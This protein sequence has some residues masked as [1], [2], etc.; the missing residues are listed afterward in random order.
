MSA[1][2]LAEVAQDTER[3]MEQDLA[4]GFRQLV[5]IAERALSPAV[6]D[7]TTACQ[8]LDVLHDLLRRLAVRH[9]PSGRLHGADGSLRLIV[10]QYGFAD[11][12][13]LAIG[14]IWHYGS[15]AAQVPGRLSAMLADLSAAALP[16]YL[17]VLRQWADRIDGSAAGREAAVSREEL[18]RI[19]I[20]SAGV[21]SCPEGSKEPARRLAACDVIAAAPVAGIDG[22]IGPASPFGVADVNRKDEARH[23]RIAGCRH[24]RRQRG[25]CPRRRAGIRVAG[26]RWTAGPWPRPAWTAPRETSRRPAAVACR[27][28]PTSPTTTRWRRRRAQSS[29]NSARSTSG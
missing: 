29:P 15:D 21:G 9:L 8:A 2:L 27:C 18:C 17:P 4:F 24:H 14:E 5:D 3:T 22:S 26:R 23:E 25:H 7:P 13:D 20:K 28:R 16:E 6:N 19:A 10:P 12:V 11:F 1:R